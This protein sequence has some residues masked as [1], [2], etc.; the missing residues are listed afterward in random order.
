MFFFLSPLWDGNKH[1]GMKSEGGF[2]FFSF[3]FFVFFTRTLRTMVPLTIHF[4]STCTYLNLLSKFSVEILYRSFLSKFFIEIYRNFL[5][6]T[7]SKLFIETPYSNPTTTTYPKPPY[8]PLSKTP[9]LKTPPLF[10]KEKE[11]LFVF[12]NQKNRNPKIDFIIDFIFK[13]ITY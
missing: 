12:K 7:W 2:F 13:T 10:K 5:S 11:I 4:H 9:S 8:N 1:F 3:F 6:K